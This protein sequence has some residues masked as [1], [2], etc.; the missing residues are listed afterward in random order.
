V[1]ESPNPP[2]PRVGSVIQGR[3]RILDVVASGGMGVVYRGERLQLGR[4]VAIKFLHPWVASDP[5]F[6]QRFNVEAHAMSRLNH[7][8]CVSVIDFGVENAPF[9][10]M[11][12]VAGR[13]LRFVIENEKL[14]PTRVLGL[15]RQI[16]SGL[17][18]AHAQGIVHRDLKPENIVVTDSPGLVDHVRILDFG[19]AKLHD[20]PSLTV[21]IAVGTPSYMAPEQTLEDGI[22]DGRT[23]IYAVGLLLFEMLSGRKPFVSDN[24]A[25]LLL[26]RQ[27]QPAPRMGTDA[28]GARFSET[29]EAF[30]AKALAKTPSD[31]FASADE[32][33]QALEQLPE[34]TAQH[35]GVAATVVAPSPVDAGT[36][37]ASGIDQTISDQT[38]IDTRPLAAPEKLA[39]ARPLPSFRK[40]WS[41][42]RRWLVGTAVGAT[43]GAVCGSLLLS[44][45]KATKGPEVRKVPSP[46]VQQA[47]RSMDELSPMSPD[48]TPGLAEAAQLV[49]LG[50]SDQAITVLQ[51]IRRNYPLSAYANFLL[52]VTYFDK[53][54]WSIGRE[55]AEAAMNL[56][57][58]YRRSP[59]LARVFIRSLMSESFREKAAAILEEDLAEVAPPYLQEAAQYD[60]S[61]RVRAR[62]AQILANIA[63]R[64]HAVPPSGSRGQ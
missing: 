23:D 13:S 25:E 9:L 35:A 51:D 33:A 55:H 21:G 39:P 59:K 26:M 48:S 15:V 40:T 12:F 58:A 8:N 43:L 17:S 18:H 1:T 7:P 10:V 37:A 52:A 61:A 44:T 53:M 41:R 63:A 45:H 20:G 3:Y 46:A 14:P 24:V 60:R 57:P 49:R 4:P 2:D 28:T 16:L 22:I 11:D 6:L 62:A 64:T 29:I 5:S 31:R 50:L 30:V 19:L 47:P 56:D 54:W 36:S 42:R 27:R 38:L 34:R 32:M